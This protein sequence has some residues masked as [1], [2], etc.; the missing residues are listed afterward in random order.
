MTQ[1]EHKSIRR[2][3]EELEK[4]LFGQSGGARPPVQQRRPPIA[5]PNQLVTPPEYAA[6]WAQSEACVVDFIVKHAPD[7]LRSF[8]LTP[9]KVNGAIVM[10]VPGCVSTAEPF[11][12]IALSRFNA[13][14]A[15]K[16]KEANDFC[17]QA[18][19]RLAA[20]L[21]DYSRSLAPM[22]LNWYPVYAGPMTV[23]PPTPN[24]PCPLA[25]L[26]RNNA[27]MLAA[28]QLEH[29]VEK[30]VDRQ[31]GTLY[32]NL[33]KPGDVSL[34]KQ[35]C[36]SIAEQLSRYLQGLFRDSLVTGVMAESLARVHA[37]PGGP[38]PMP[39]IGMTQVTGD[40]I[41]VI[42]QWRPEWDRPT[43]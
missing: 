40:F 24:T 37:G 12:G 17:R 11:N 31:W 23:F 29:V 25:D 22:G 2:R 21:D 13:A 35:V 16:R 19:N 43:G 6:L 15:P 38:L 8:M 32:D 26:G 41:K 39:F 42:E 30:V 28:M 4:K 20:H 27:H 9:C 5:N 10:G 33:L 1:A 7:W 36:K 34:S 14:N 18:I 3:A